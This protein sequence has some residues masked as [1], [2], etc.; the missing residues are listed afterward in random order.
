MIQK[1]WYKFL[2]LFSN[3]I[4]ISYAVTVCNEAQELD[5]LLRILSSKIGQNDEIIIL[6]DKSNVT[7]EV[8]SV[9]KR[10]QTGRSVTHISHP[11][12][13]D[14]ASFKNILISNATK[15]YL[16]QIDADEYPNDKI[17]I[18]LKP[19]LF[20]HILFDCFLVPR[21]NFVNGITQAHIDKWK[22]RIDSQ[23][24]INYP[25]YQMRIFKLNKNIHWK[26]KVHEK[27]VNYTIKKRLPCETENFCLYHIKEIVKQ[28][29]QNTLYDSML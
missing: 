19:Y 13:G 3:R 9:I 29:K 24:R 8:K 17:F 15:K 20:G 21:V 27:L 12:E 26:N 1:I 18:H 4:S 10:Y 2:Q 28:E 25:D 16:F 11:L 5:N 6:S 14:F 22:W 23:N 7:E